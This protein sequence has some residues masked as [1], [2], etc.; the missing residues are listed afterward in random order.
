MAVALSLD[1]VLQYV[2]VAARV[3][4]AMLV[5]PVFGLRLAPALGRLGLGLLTALV[6]TPVLPPAVGLPASDRLL[7]LIGW[8]VLVGLAAGFAVALVFACAQVA[9]G[10]L[11][12]Q[13]GFSLA[14]AY[15]PTF[16][17]QETVI[18][19]YLVA[20]ATLIFLQIDGHHWA[21]VG[22]QQLLVRVPIGEPSAI[23]GLDA[24]IG[25]S[26]A[27]F[28]MAL[29]LALPVLASLLLVDLAMG[30][31]GRTMPQLNLL[32]L[33]LPIKTAVGLLVIGYAMPFLGSRLAD[34]FGS[35]PFQLGWLLTG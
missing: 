20:F 30:V 10:L 3:T 33:S 7:L 14:T 16:T 24:L 34:L 9:A 29:R 12:V 23:H 35:I 1:A 19:R 21:L 11:D 28:A 26:S 31:V 22:L 18:E 2:L 4:S 32:A 5:M 27:I 25:L 13:I 17:S 8:E 6:I 15:D